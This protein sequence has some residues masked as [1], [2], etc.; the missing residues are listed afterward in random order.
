MAPKNCILWEIFW[1]TLFNFFWQIHRRYGRICV[2]WGKLWAK[3]SFLDKFDGM[4]GGTCVLW[5][6]SISRP[7]SLFWPGA[8]V[9]IM[10]ISRWYGDLEI[11]FLLYLMPLFCR[12]CWCYFYCYF[13]Q[14][15]RW[16]AHQADQQKIRGFWKCKLFN[17]FVVDAPTAAVII[18]T[19]SSRTYDN[20]PI[21]PSNPTHI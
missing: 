12:C 14:G 17:M 16:G 21:H 3:K 10:W 15:L 4:Y 8:E 13:D 11:I 7:A 9:P 18:G 2:L 1:T 5:E 6:E 20:H 19:E